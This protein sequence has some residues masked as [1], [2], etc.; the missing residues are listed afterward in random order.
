MTQTGLHKV[1][2]VIIY[3]VQIA[4]YLHCHNQ[5]IKLLQNEKS[6][7]GEHSEIIMLMSN[8]METYMHSVI[9]QDVCPMKIQH[10]HSQNINVY[11]YKVFKL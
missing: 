6:E 8:S 5:I 9:C 3:Y 10:Q 7:H 1:M 11:N 4:R 2:D